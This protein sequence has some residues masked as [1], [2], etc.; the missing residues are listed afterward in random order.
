MMVINDVMVG[1]VDDLFAFLKNRELDPDDE[2]GP[3]PT[4]DATGVLLCEVNYDT[5]FVLVY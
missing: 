4:L 2:Q 1:D 5:F 3:T